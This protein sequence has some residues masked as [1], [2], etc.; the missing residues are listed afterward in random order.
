M[1]REFEQC[2]CHLSGSPD[3]RR[4]IGRDLKDRSLGRLGI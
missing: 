4:F 3:L 2:L 1:N